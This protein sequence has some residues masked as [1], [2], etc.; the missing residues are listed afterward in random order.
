MSTL[1]SQRAPLSSRVLGIA[2]F[3][4]RLRRGPGVP[5]ATTTSW[6]ARTPGVTNGVPKRPASNLNKQILQQA[7]GLS[8]SNEIHGII[9]HCLFVL[10]FII[11]KTLALLVLGKW[12]SGVNL[13]AG[14]TRFTPTIPR[15]A[16]RGEFAL[17]R[18][19]S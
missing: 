9:R 16:C 7:P 8:C 12:Q 2:A 18:W 4:A 15:F 6:G 14:G 19:L 11:L 3:A 17:R 10:F 1:R 13:Q 5:L